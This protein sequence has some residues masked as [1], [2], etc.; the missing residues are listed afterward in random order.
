VNDL[1]ANKYHHAELLKPLLTLLHPFAPFISEYLWLQSGETKSILDS[2]YPVADESLLI[3]NTFEYPVSVN[4]KMR[5]KA[6]F[7]LDKDQKEIEAET[8][9]LESVQKWMEGKPVKK[10]IFV[11]GR[12]INIVV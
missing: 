2:V 10:I 1:S 5:T 7:P 12:M 8:I 11:K 9:Q 3:E 6:L 4:G